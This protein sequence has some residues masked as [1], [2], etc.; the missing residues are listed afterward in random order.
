MAKIL[1]V[2]DD[3]DNAQPLSA[4]FEANGYEARCAAD[5]AEALRIF[6]EYMPDAVVTD[7]IMPGLDGYGLARKLRDRAYDRPIIAVT[8][9]DTDKYPNLILYVDR[10]FMKPLNTDDVIGLIRAKVGPP[11][12]Q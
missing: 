4:L 10:I 2:D 8:G 9:A 6:A 7:I 11:E 3:A 5:G 1:I 12:S